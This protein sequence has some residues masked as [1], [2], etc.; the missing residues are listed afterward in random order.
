MY[1][2]ILLGALFIIYGSI[3]AQNYF[4]TSSLVFEI[5]PTPKDIS[6]E[7]IISDKEVSISN[8][9]GGTGT[10]K[11]DIT[12]KEEKEFNYSDCIWYKGTSKQT[13]SV[14]WVVIMRKES[15]TEIDLFQVNEE[16]RIK[17]TKIMLK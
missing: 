3:N 16:V 4:S 10:L 2:S 11:I 12:S 9:L 17:R 13:G 14:K 15:P 1:K 5:T 6:R 8:Y 7:V